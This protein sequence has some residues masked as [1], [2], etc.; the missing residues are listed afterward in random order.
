MRIFELGWAN[1]SPILPAPE[2]LSGKQPRTEEYPSFFTSVAQT[3]SAHL[4]RSHHDP[5]PVPAAAGGVLAAH[6]DG[7]LPLHHVVPRQRQVSDHWIDFMQI[8]TYSGL[9]KL[10]ENLP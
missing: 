5:V 6:A 10:D 2:L 7:A 8:T 9:S 1:Q 3:P 4:L